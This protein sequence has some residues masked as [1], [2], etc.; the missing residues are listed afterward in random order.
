MHPCL[1]TQQVYHWGVWWSHRVL[2]QGNQ[3]FS[4]SLLL[5]HLFKDICA[6]S[7]ISTCLAEASKANSE[8][9]APPILDYLKEFSHIFSKKSSDTLPEHKQWD[10]TIELVPGEKP[11]SCKIYLLAP[12]EQ[13]E[14]DA[15]LEENLETGQ[16]CLSK[17]LMSSPVFFIKKKDGSL[18]LVQDYQALNAITVKNKYPLLSISELVNKLQGAQYFT[19]LNVQWHMIQWLKK[20]SQCLHDLER[21]TWCNLLT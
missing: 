14:L 18:R 21:S 12:S 8:A 4:S 16:I 11:S 15:F 7:T 5:P 20:M 3:I 6:L 19:K 10:H 17:S 2:D 9:N 1:Y 13:K